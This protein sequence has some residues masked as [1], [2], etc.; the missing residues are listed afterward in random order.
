MATS[1]S[2]STSQGRTSSPFPVSSIPI[3]DL[4][5]IDC[6]DHPERKLVLF[7]ANTEKNR[8]RN[9]FRCMKNAR[10][11]DAYDRFFW[12]NEYYTYLVN[13]GFLHEFHIGD[14]DGVTHGHATKEGSHGVI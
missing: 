11:A 5:L 7:T 13:N 3:D 14:G 6:P 8:G 4:P 1:A 2:G 9:F 10:R 12:E